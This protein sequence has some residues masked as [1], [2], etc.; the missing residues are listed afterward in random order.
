MRLHTAAGN[1]RRMRMTRRA[2]A[3]RLRSKRARPASARSG[4]ELGHHDRAEAVFV[5]AAP[6]RGMPGSLVDVRRR[7]PAAIGD[8]AKATR[9]LRLGVPPFDLDAV[10]LHAASRTA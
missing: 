3:T 5:S 8:G 9:V 6:G 10:A 7:A 1:W 4:A 2:S